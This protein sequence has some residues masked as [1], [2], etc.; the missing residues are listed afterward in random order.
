MKAI[1]LSILLFFSFTESQSTIVKNKYSK[2]E[3]IPEKILKKNGYY[4]FGIKL[5]LNEGWKTYW[6]NPGE[7][8]ASI[9]ANWV[10]NSG[11][12]ETEILFPFPKKYLD[13][14]VTTIGYDKKV[15]FPVLIKLEP[16][17][18]EINKE[19]VINYLICKEICIPLT[20]KLNVNFSI[21]DS[22]A[23]K[24]DDQIS[25]YLKKIPKIDSGI[26]Q[27]DEIIKINE[28]K[29]QIFFKFDDYFKKNY[30]MFSFS[31]DSNSRLELV[32]THERL[33]AFIDFDENIN[34]I[35]TP[36]LIS[37]S[38]GK[39]L[40]EI[41][42]NKEDI[43]TKSSLIYFLLLA[44]I[45]GL[46]LN[47]M[48]CV[49]PVLSL[50]LYSLV[51]ISE[52]QANNIR[53]YSFASFLGIIFSFILLSL[54]I[55]L[56]KVIG[57]D[58]GWGFQFQ[59]FGFLLV[60][61]C[62]IFIFCINLLGFFEIL[63]PSTLSNK[64]T[65][66]ASEQSF[67]S[68]FLSGV[69]STLMAT[70]C[71]A[72]FLGTAIGFSITS[73]YQNIIIIFIFISFGFALPYII[74]SVRPSL[75]SIL[76]KPGKW[77]ENFKLILGLILLITFGWFLSLMNFN[78]FTII[79]LTFII[80]L[81]FIFLKR[82]QFSIIT[83]VVCLTIIS[84]FLIPSSKDSLVWEKFD[85]TLLNKQIE[86]GDLILLDFTASWC[87]TCQVNKITTLDSKKLK[88]FIIQN[89]VKIMRGDWSKRDKD[90][91]EFISKYGRFGIPVN[92]VFGPKDGKGIILPEILSKDIVIN[93]LNL[94]K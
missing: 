36:I 47:F 17:Q 64:L 21:D 80:L 85:E 86:N 46:I 40:E 35:K 50:K 52:S 39:N 3:I 83:S 66:F 38:D 74:S 92:I 29:I 90:I 2:I 7:A 51:K 94:I 71:S 15:V 79:T 12:L 32:Q 53:K 27:I 49:L 91:L 20:E 56:F 8:G 87:V 55:I 28:K 67:R 78:A 45:G 68:Y 31:K 26:F 14:G 25:Q 69:F 10:D 11:I 43:K 30:E 93:Q 1:F 89:N 41:Q 13:H 75:V 82:N 76:P 88:D 16:E 81:Y 44:F 73:S 77:M 24:F 65:S 57:T 70:P 60:V 72:P 84:Y 34:E 37:I 18:K 42:I 4:L 48:P 23:I 54:I 22:Y 33:S 58:L 9:S 59:N 61:S 19:L 5:L 62:I 6:K 63:L